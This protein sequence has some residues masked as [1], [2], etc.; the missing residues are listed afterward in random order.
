MC[1]VLCYALFFCFLSLFARVVFVRMFRELGICGLSMNRRLNASFERSTCLFMFVRVYCV[2]VVNCVLCV[3]C[4]SVCVLSVLS[5]VCLCC[6]V[7][8][9]CAVCLCCVCAVCP[10]SWVAGTMF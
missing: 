2:C 10:V 3:C 1:A 4:V 7:C 8:D 9:V 6:A 5:A